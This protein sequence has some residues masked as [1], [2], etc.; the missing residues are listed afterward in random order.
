MFSVSDKIPYERKN[1]FFNFVEYEDYIWF[2][3]VIYNALYRCKKGESITQ[4]MTPKINFSIFSLY[5]KIFLYESK[6]ICE[7]RM[8]DKIL[9]YDT[10]NK[11]I[12]YV[13]LEIIDG[14]D[15]SLREGIFWDGK[16]SG[17][18]LYLIGLCSPYIVKFNM[19]TEKTEIM[20]NPYQKIKNDKDRKYFYWKAEIFDN[21]LFV[22]SYRD[23]FVFLINTDKMIYYKKYFGSIKK[24]G[25]S[26]L[27]VDREFVWLFHQLD[28]RIICWNYK[29]NDIKYYNQYPDEYDFSNSKIGYIQE[30]NEKLYLFS[31]KKNK[32][33]ILEKN[34]EISYE[35]K[36]N[37]YYDDFLNGKDYKG[38]TYCFVQKQNCCL[39]ICVCVSRELLVYSFENEKIYSYSFYVPEAD[40]K[41]FILENFKKEILDFERGNSL[42]YFVGYIINNYENKKNKGVDNLITVGKQIYKKVNSFI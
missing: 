36:I 32:I 20:I 22:P 8:T 34:G 21:I 24:G 3:D 31:L 37:H 4:R 16:V 41:Y 6:I 39:Y 7:P 40:Y 14:G 33:L 27:Y 18:Y 2:W 15:L 28:K 25:F 30:V 13:C 1:V 17:K 10:E 35:E 23:N 29:T 12:R 9:I 26:S 5:S 11:E 19:E 42:N 38:D